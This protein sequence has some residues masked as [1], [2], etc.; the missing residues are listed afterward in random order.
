M[1]KEH[2]TCGEQCL[3]FLS[4][5][6]TFWSIHGVLFGILKKMMPEIEEVNHPFLFF[7]SLLVSS[8]LLLVAITYA[9]IFVI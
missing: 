3:G 7:L 4:I 2:P 1:P 5:D 9:D 6:P 8:K